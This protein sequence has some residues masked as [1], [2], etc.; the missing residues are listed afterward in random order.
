MDV[1]AGRLAEA[2]A[3]AV[4]ILAE[5]GGPE[6]DGG[7]AVGRVGGRAAECGTELPATGPD[8]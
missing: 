3:D 5:L 8:L 7:P 4:A 2:H 1:V 6:P